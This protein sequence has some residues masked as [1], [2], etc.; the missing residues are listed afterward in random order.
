MGK[1]GS[2]PVPSSFQL[3]P[4]GDVE[5]LPGLFPNTGFQTDGFRFAFEIGIRRRIGLAGRSRHG[6]WS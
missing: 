1:N 6:S 5:T 2:K 3:K 4:A